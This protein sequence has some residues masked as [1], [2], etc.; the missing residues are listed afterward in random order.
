M[1]R[2]RRPRVYHSFHRQY[3]RDRYQLALRHVDRMGRDG[4]TRLI[5]LMYRERKYVGQHGH[6]HPVTN[7]GGRPIQWR[8]W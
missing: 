8:L 7:R 2:R 1:S 4:Q 6:W 3:P 5:R